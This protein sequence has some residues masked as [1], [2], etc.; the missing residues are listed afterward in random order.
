VGG[1]QVVWPPST[2]SAV[3]VVKEASSEHSHSTAEAISSGL[4]ILPIGSWASTAWRPSGVSPKTRSIMW[5][6]MMP[7]QTALIRTLADA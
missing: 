1:R 5:V 6:S 2:T 7:G 4:P 3:P